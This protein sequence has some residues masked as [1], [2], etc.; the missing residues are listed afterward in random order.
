MLIKKKEPEVVCPLNLQKRDQ[1]SKNMNN[2]EDGT[3][4]K[5][6]RILPYHLLIPIEANVLTVRCK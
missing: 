1:S 6:E 3:E 2:K 4:E 5:W